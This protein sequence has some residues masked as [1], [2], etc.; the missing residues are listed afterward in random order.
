MEF[1]FASHSKTRKRSKQ[2]KNIDFIKN[3]SPT[4]YKQQHID[5]KASKQELEGEERNDDFNMQLVQYNDHKHQKI[6]IDSKNCHYKKICQKIE[7]SNTESYDDGYSEDVINCNDESRFTNLQ[8][9]V[10]QPSPNIFSIEEEYFFE[11]G[12]NHHGQRRNSNDDLNFYAPVYKSKS[13]KTT[14]INHSNSA[15]KPMKASF[16][17][18]VFDKYVIKDQ[19]LN[20][21]H[22]HDEGNECESI[23]INLQEEN[24]LSLSRYANS[25]KNKNKESDV[26][27]NIPQI[28][29]YKI[30]R[31]ESFNTHCIDP[32]NIQKKEKKR[33]IPIS[34]SNSIPDLKNQLEIS[35][36]NAK[37][38]EVDS[39]EVNNNDNQSNNPL[40]KK[41]DRYGW[42]ITENE[43][44]TPQKIKIL[45]LESAIEFKREQK[46][47]KMIKN[48]D[49]FMSNKLYKIK[50]RIKKGIPDCLRSKVWQL[51][52]DPDA[53]SIKQ[54]SEN[55][56]NKR[57]SI[58]SYILIGRS[59]CCKT[60]EADL[61][62]TMPHVKM[63]CD[64]TAI[65]SLREILHA[66]SNKDAEIGYYQ[67]MAFLAAILLVYLDEIQ[68][69]WCFVNLMNGPHLQFRRLYIHK[70]SGLND[71]NKLWEKLLDL[72][73]PKVSH[74]LKEE[75]IY[76]ILYTPAWFLSSYIS[77]PF[78]P[79]LKLRIFDRILMF[80]ARALLS[81][82]LVIIALNKKLLETE[83]ATKILLYLQHPDEHE[84]FKDW[85]NVIS[86]FDEHWLS[87]SDYDKLFKITNV[88]KF[89]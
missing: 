72:K 19:H 86:K 82:G 11:N 2:E 65:N 33:K 37:K 4:K 53:C 69:F 16:Q 7:S 35:K 56:E 28:G 85:R 59:K 3:S 47:I 87:Q 70:F 64:E 9:T 71:L 52:L 32:K 43:I 50:S 75:K 24:N 13:I 5:H 1:H 29:Y 22:F 21:S 12:I 54:N 48:W 34:K 67:G 78:E 23:S 80:G 84:A 76:P 79:T 36:T 38:D 8:L 74:N 62:R 26:S 42:F 27:I 83:K 89:F 40:N 18:S 58:Q 55:Q 57:P 73:F 44:M 63:F 15:F 68:A 46:W 81:F 39:N 77:L 25:D 51:I 45:Q 31:A 30:E 10:S 14:N 60:I 20:K 6:G 61:H 88:Q 66:Y 17:Q 41:T 49:Y